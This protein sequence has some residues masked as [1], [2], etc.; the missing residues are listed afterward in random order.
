VRDLP[1]V[2]DRESPRRDSPLFLFLLFCRISTFTLGGGPVIIGVVRAE[3][4]RR[5]TLDEEEI[6]RLLGMAMAMP[7][8]IA[9]SAAFLVGR[10][11]SGAPGAAASVL[12]A[13]LPPFG[14][15]LLLSPFVFAHRGD[16]R[17]SAFFSGVLCAAGAVACRTVFREIRSLAR[18]ELPLLLPWALAA[19]LV[20][21]GFHPL[22]GLAAGG[23]GAEILRLFPGRSRE[24]PGIPSAG[25]DADPGRSPERKP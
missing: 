5:G 12:G 19:G 1:G 17:L 22:W 14:A 7:G 4:E 13:V 23:V 16:P 20:L 15:I 10:R 24:K 8:P 11:L 18:F 6:G 21:A 3:L 2:P 9:V 25:L